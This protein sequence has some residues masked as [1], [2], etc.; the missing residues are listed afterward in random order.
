MAPALSHI[1]CCA[2]NV[3]SHPHKRAW[4]ITA[5]ST[6]CATS[7]TSDHHRAQIVQYY[8]L[9]IFTSHITPSSQSLTLCRTA[10][11]KVTLQLQ[12]HLL[13]SVCTRAARVPVTTSSISRAPCAVAI[14]RKQQNNRTALTA[15]RTV[16][17]HVHRRLFSCRWLPSH[18][19]I[20]LYIYG[21]CCVYAAS[22][23]ESAPHL[24]R[25]ALCSDACFTNRAP[26]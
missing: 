8:L 11:A 1:L 26:V 25:R 10:T 15:Y 20:A 9:I 14:A 23:G 22:T 5:L 16:I 4:H 24:F 13:G 2:H 19:T 6:L 17:A 18:S 7:G 3:L 12:K 21:N